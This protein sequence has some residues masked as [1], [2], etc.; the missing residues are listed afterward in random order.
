MNKINREQGFTLLEIIVVLA[1]SG[2]LVAAFA[3]PISSILFR[4]SD[5]SNR[6]TAVSNL[7]NAAVWIDKDVQMALSTDLDSGETST[8]EIRL[9]SLDE[10][11][12]MHEVVYTASGN[13]LVRQEFINETM[14]SERTI[15]RHITGAT[16]YRLQGG[17]P[18]IKVS[19]SASGAEMSSLN[20]SGE[21]YVRLRSA[22]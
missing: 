3:S 22:N 14:D 12:D 20:E 17:D 9:M 6:V 19:L 7:Q 15:S 4:T 5:Q 1:V 18:V 2:I 10:N 21:Y 13:E 11:G 16:F 8:G